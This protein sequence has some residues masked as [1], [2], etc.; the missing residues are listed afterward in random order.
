MLGGGLSKAHGHLIPGPVGV[1]LKSSK[2]IKRVLHIF[3]AMVLTLSHYTW[4]FLL[5]LP[6]LFE[7]KPDPLMSFLAY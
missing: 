3:I 5:V 2:V 7:L 6:L 1:L 4:I